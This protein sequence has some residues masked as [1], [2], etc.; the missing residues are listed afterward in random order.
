MLLTRKYPE[1]IKAVM[2]AIRTA[3]SEVITQGK[4]ADSTSE[5]IAA[6][7]CSPDELVAMANAYWDRELDKLN[8][9]KT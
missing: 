7:I 5:A 9:Q 6:E 4:I 8:T 1:K 2:D 3:G